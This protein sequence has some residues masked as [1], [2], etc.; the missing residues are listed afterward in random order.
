[1]AVNRIAVIDYGM[2]NLHSVASALK[3]VAPEAEVIVTADPQVVA[4]AD[5]VV[6]PGVGAIRDCM[7]ELKNRGLDEIVQEVA[8][9]KPLLGICV[10]MQ[11]MA[12][13]GLEKQTTSGLGWIAGD[14][15]EMLP[16]DETLKIPQ[17]GWNTLTVQQ[18]HPLLDG[19]ELGDNG[20]HAY[21]VHSYHMAVTND[22]HRL[23]HV[24]Y[25][26]D[27]TAIIGRD[28]MLGMQFHPEKSAAAGL[29]LL[30]NFL[31][32]NGQC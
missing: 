28:T 24:D 4:A 3:K 9:T 18:P 1:M 21:F 22:A 16:Q 6:F 11:L 17:I 5:R 8:A 13:R 31:E 27:V 30:K 12:T 10:G 25:A 7:A 32:W 29:T 15:V 19:I 23:A 20:L 2:G 14:V 26:G